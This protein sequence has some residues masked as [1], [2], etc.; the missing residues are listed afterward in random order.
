MYIVLKLASVRRNAIAAP[1]RRKKN[2]CAVFAVAECTLSRAL[3]VNAIDHRQEVTGTGPQALSTPVNTAQK[4]DG[5]QNS[6]TT[7]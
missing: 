4:T 2:V 1:E 6:E 7:N 5:W 3:S